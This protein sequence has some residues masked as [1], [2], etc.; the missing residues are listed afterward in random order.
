MALYEKARGLQGMGKELPHAARGGSSHF[1]GGWEFPP[2]RP[3]RSRA[4]IRIPLNEHI[5]VD[6]LAKR[7]LWRIVGDAGVNRHMR[8]RKFVILKEP[9]LRASRRMAH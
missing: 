5:E 2:R 6:S 7:R 9:R 3:R 8:T 1:T 4:P